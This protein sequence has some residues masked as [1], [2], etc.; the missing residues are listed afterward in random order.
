M[1]TPH[2]TIRTSRSPRRR[3]A[4][5]MTL[6][7]LMIAVS[8]MALLATVVLP[9]MQTDSSL[10][11]KSTARVLVA[12]LRLARSYALRHGASYRVVFNLKANSYEVE[13]VDSTSS[14]QPANPL[15]PNSTAAGMYQVELDRLAMTSQGGARVRL[16]GVGLRD[17]QRPVRDVTFGPAGG[18]GPDR[19]ED[20][21]IWLT[22][23][24]GENVH[25]IRIVISWV[26]GQ[27]W[28]DAPESYPP[29]SP[30]RLYEEL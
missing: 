6:I 16:L 19:T 28:L 14:P 30:T 1:K 2:R 11:L 5:G 8:I 21:L 18:T 20:T 7:E 26:T 25:Y 4:G 15:D 24:S 27:V 22:Q 12:D 10:T 23:N 17:S 9:S 3:R 29:S 13:P